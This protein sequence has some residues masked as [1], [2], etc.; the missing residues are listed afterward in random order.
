MGFGLVALYYLEHF[1]EWNLGD[2]I[3]EIP[4][5]VIKVGLN[6]VGQTVATVLNA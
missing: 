3:L 1:L 2:V 4:V 5:N 6:T